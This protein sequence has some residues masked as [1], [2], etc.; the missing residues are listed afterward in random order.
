MVSFPEVTKVRMVKV[1]V[2]EVTRWFLDRAHITTA[3]EI[4]VGTPGYRVDP[5]ADRSQKVRIHTGEVCPI[6]LQAKRS[7]AL[8]RHF[9][10]TALIAVGRLLPVALHFKLRGRKIKFIPR[11][12]S[13]RE[14]H[15]GFER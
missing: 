14:A 3:L 9:D 13:N 10:S 11:D 7:R 8:N 6:D 1:G 15:R 5:K 12:A 2:M 4:I